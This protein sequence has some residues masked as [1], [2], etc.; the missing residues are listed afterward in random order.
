M[1]KL[2][3]FYFSKLLV[4]KSK[5]LLAKIIQS[6]TVHFYCFLFKAEILASHLAEFW[7][8]YLCLG[9]TN[10]Y[11]KITRNALV[12]LM[13]FALVGTPQNCILQ[14]SLYIYLHI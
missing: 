10:F 12:G 6:N 9:L 3:E 8:R 11:K 2:Y 4:K 7:T 13:L 1:S 5:A 14:E